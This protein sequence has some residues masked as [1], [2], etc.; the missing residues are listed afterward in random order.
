MPM[1][2]HARL[3]VSSTTARRSR[4]IALALLALAMLPATAHAAKP[5]EIAVQDD[6][7]L[8]RAND[9]VRA[10]AWKRIEQMRA[11]YVRVNLYWNDVV[12][13]ATSRTRP[14]RIRYTLDEYDRLVAEARK[15]KVQVQMTLG[16]S[17][18]AWATSNRKVG[19]TNPNAKL[20]AAFARDMAKHYK[21]KVGRYS[22]MNEPNL[23]F[24]LKPVKTSAK[25]YAKI[26]K[27]SYSAIKRADRNAKVF[28]G[29][30]A[31][32]T[33]SKK[34]GTDPLLWIK[35]V[36]RGQR[37]KTDGVAHHPYAFDASPRK[38]F[39]GKNTITMSSLSRLVKLLRTAQKKK[40]L[41]TPRGGRPGIYLTE[42]GYFVDGPQA[43][44]YRRSQALPE[45][46]RATYW[47]QSLDIARKTSTV[48]QILSYQLYPTTPD[49]TWDTSV[50][51]GAG[52]PTAVF[53]SITDWVAR[54]KR[55][56]I[57]KPKAYKAPKAKKK[58]K[59]K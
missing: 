5:L 2:P 59:K 36:L 14:S 11:S 53:T 9:D 26:Y 45:N 39:R 51:D 20:F 22:I 32:F 28:F 57:V 58:A 10:H 4:L 41:R 8:L 30:T 13:N 48:R 54:A 3:D 15:H 33:R 6:G 25:Q 34:N 37:L 35:R 47:K 16:T 46:T 40:Q 42:H 55:G 29:E 18:P 31:P 19:K 7:I 38:P 12:N 17:A 1:F 49:A 50:L 23:I 24:W 43:P 44:E 21:G 52:N 56:W 27:L